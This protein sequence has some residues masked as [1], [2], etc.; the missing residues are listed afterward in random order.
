MELTVYILL[1]ADGSYYVGSTKQEIEARVWE[2]NEGVHD[3]Y[4]KLRRP[5]TLV[6]TETYDRLTDGHARER[7]IKGWSRARSS[8]PLVGRGRGGV[9][10]AHL[11]RGKSCIG[12]GALFGTVM[13]CARFS[14]PLVGRGR[15]GGRSS[16]HP[17]REKLHRRRS[18]FWSR[19]GLRAPT[20]A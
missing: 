1:C 10:P 3:G 17:V 15:G 4:T 12:G 2:H 7:Q 9:G 19:D 11:W 16:P 6:F 18:A 5:V 14:L 8:L 13:G 20:P